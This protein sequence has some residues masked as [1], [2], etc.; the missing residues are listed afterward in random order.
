MIRDLISKG[1]LSRL[2]ATQSYNSKFNVFVASLCC[3]NVKTGQLLQTVML[4]DGLLH[5]ACLR[6]YSYC[7][8]VFALYGRGLRVV[9][10]SSHSSGD[11]TPVCFCVYV[12]AQ[13]VLFVLLQHQLLTSLEEEERDARAQDQMF[14]KEEEDNE[15]ER[16]KTTL[17]SLG[18]VNPL[19]GKSVLATRL[20]PPKA[21]SGR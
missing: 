3:R 8:S 21:W 18:A 10:I 13:G 6:G 5:T 19:N 7:V 11:F 15:E 16:K 9:I 2:A 17:F 12:C 20:C 4:G 1:D 14:S